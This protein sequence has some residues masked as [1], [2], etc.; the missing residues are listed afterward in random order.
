MGYPNEWELEASLKQQITLTSPNPLMKKALD[1]IQSKWKGAEVLLST[2]FRFR[3]DCIQPDCRM[4]YADVEVPEVS[5]EKLGENFKFSTDGAT[6][7]EAKK[8]TAGISAEFAEHFEKPKAT[9]KAEKDGSGCVTLHIRVSTERKLEGHLKFKVGTTEVELFGGKDPPKELFAEGR[10]KICCCV[11]AEE[12]EKSDN[13]E[14]PGY[15]PDGVPSKCGYS[16]VLLRWDE[17]T[18]GATDLYWECKAP[19]GA[20][21][22]PKKSSNL[23]RVTPQ[24]GMPPK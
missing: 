7:E 24:S 4:D 18:G 8:V 21:C 2:K 15:A 13:P 10:V 1:A 17:Q 16:V 11:C 14:S 12:G 3:F 23:P 5:W 20:C 9:F 19:L 22:K 6:D